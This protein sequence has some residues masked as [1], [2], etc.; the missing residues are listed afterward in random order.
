MLQEY[1]SEQ[2]GDWDQEDIDQE[3]ILFVMKEVTQDQEDI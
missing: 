1:G 2:V 3:C